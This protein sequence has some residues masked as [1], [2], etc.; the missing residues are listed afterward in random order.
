MNS[1]DAVQCTAFMNTRNSDRRVVVLNFSSMFQ[2]GIILLLIGPLVPSLMVTFGVGESLTGLL[3]A[4]GS[5]GFVIGLFFAGAVIDRVNVRA[6]LVVGLT[7]EILGLVLF[8]LAPVFAVAVI[9]GFVLR[10]GGS[11]IEAAANVMP[12]LTA[13][14]RAPHAVMNLVHMFFSVGAFV[15]PFLIGL[16]LQATGQWRPVMLFALV[17][18]TGVLLG[19][20]LIRIPRNVSTRPRGPDTP[21]GV[22]TAAA[23]RPIDGRRPVSQLFDV[24]KR[25]YVFL[26]AVTLF[27]YV[28]AEVGLSSWI[29]YY[30]Q[31]ELG[32]APVSSAVGLSVLWVAIMVGRFGNSI[33]GDRFS[34]TT[35][36][37]V[38]GFGG[39][40]G[41]VAFLFVR[42][43]F[44]AYL[45]LA[46]IGLC[47]SGVF[48]NVMA[49]LNNRDPEKTGTVTAVMAMG[50]S[51]GA[52]AAQWF[53]G[54]LAET[55]SLSAAF[56]T[57]AVLQGLLVLSFW[58]AL[59][60]RR[61][62]K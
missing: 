11:F 29:V 28:G 15:G 23:P 55:V 42:T 20:I 22:K 12:T 45:V 2:H 19:A 7:A 57:P 41:A 37:T 51:S 9:A 56:V 6:A 38:S 17:P 24:V 61:P 31:K 21:A 47:L 10:F 25:K 4:L 54:F 44:P 58:G 39:A 49:E 14:R 35:L 26:G 5:V 62:A 32:L 52:G 33:L 53:V 1:F 27:F 34:S 13:Q 48:P 60:A 3:L 46:W 40:I 59:K 43:I 36:V 18:T 8:A 16:Y 50:A 30:L